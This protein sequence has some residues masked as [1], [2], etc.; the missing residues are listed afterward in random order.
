[1]CVAYMQT[2]HHFIEGT[3]ALGEGSWSQHPVYTEGWLQCIWE[4][5]QDT[6][7][8]V[9]MWGR[10]GRQWIMGNWGSL[11]LGPLGDRAGCPTETSHLGRGSWVLIHQLP[12]HLWLKAAPRAAFRVRG[13][14]SGNTGGAL[15]ELLEPALLFSDHYMSWSSSTYVTG[16]PYSDNNAT[17]QN[18][19]TV[20]I[21]CWF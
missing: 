21:L 4:R 8:W 17:K 5:I 20:F 13:T 3:W 14:C 7:R 9:E 11:H 15:V 1:M 18:K 10:K 6:S 2:Q 12:V 19:K 16:Q